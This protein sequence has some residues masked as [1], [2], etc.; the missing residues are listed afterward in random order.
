M[1]TDLTTHLII[2][3]K[4]NSFNKNKYIIC[5]STAIKYDHSELDK[6]TF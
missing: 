5:L 1:E 3:S 6:N 4:R 2:F